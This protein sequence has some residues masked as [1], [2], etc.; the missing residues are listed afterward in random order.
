MAIYVCFGLIDQYN[1]KTNLLITIFH[2]FI[3]WFLHTASFVLLSGNNLQFPETKSI[4][5]SI[6]KKTITQTPFEIQL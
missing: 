6:L 1:I 2:V 3:V 4:A 5:F